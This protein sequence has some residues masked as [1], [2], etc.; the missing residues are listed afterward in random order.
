MSKR[1][2]KNISLLLIIVFYI[3][4]Y[5]MFIF[6]NFMKYSEIINA[7]FS[8]VMLFLSIVL[9]GYRK[10][11]PSFLSRNILRV[12]IVHLLIVFIG[13][14]GLGFFIGFLKN[15]YSMNLS[16]LI[17]NIFSPIIMIICIELFRYVVLWANKDKKFFIVIFTIVL[18]IMEIV[19]NVRT[20]PLNDFTQLFRIVA[21]IVLPIISK[22]A[23]MSYLSYN[24]GYKIPI[25]YR[26]VMDIYLFVVP[27]IPDL[28]EYLNCMILITLPVMIYISSFTIVDEREDKDVNFIEKSNYT[29][30]DIPATV[31]LIVLAALVSGFFPHFMLGIASDSMTPVINRGDAIILKKVKTS[32]VLKKG[33]IIAYKKGDKIIVHRIVEV[34]KSGGNV[35]YVTKGDANNTKDS[36]VVY[37]KQVKGTFKIK[38]PY[39]AYPTVWLSEITNKR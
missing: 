1:S 20:L 30:K 19:F 39:I 33:Q 25:V 23:V 9:L 22:N 11:K 26:L 8:I 4:I 18:S 7:S 31:A 24:V 21:T 36:I 16:T 27:I 37:P 14:Y 12:V 34:S 35:V 17:G 29:W 28:G 32:D 5:K 15:A 13:M 6:N 38:I 2:F 10:D 3:F